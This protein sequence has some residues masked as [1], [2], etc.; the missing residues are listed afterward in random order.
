MDGEAVWESGEDQNAGQR[1]EGSAKHR[2]SGMPDMGI[3]F[4][5][6]KQARMHC[7]IAGHSVWTAHA[8]SAANK[9]VAQQGLNKGCANVAVECICVYIRHEW[10]DEMEFRHRRAVICKHFHWTTFG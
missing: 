5:F 3:V 6:N 7:T 4:Q 2:R 9:E 8:A 1:A 10:K